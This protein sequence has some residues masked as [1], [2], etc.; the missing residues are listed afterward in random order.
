MLVIY[1]GISEYVYSS[2]KQF[3]LALRDQSYTISLHSKQNY[4]S[5]LNPISK[6]NVNLFK[7]LQNFDHFRSATW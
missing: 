7:E 5:F 3:L 6:V 4:T 2:K 1:F